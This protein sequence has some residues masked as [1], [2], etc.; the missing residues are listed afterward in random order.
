MEQD[1]LSASTIESH[2]LGLA[3]NIRRLHQIAFQLRD[4]LSGDHWRAVNQLLYHPAFNKKVTIDETLAWLDAV[5]V[6][7]TT[8]S[9]FALDSMNRDTGFRFLSIGRRLERLGFMTRLFNVACNEGRDAGLTWLLELCDSVITYRSRYMSQPHWLPVM[10]L[11]VRDISNPRALMFQ[12]K[13]ILEYMHRLSPNDPGG[14]AE[15][16]KASALVQALD[17]HTDFQP[18]SVKMLEAL[19]ALHNATYTLSDELTTRFFTLP[20]GIQGNWSS[21]WH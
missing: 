10:D 17:I 3:S 16:E 9:G 4:R 11:L 13:G 6:N 15:L 2:P 12:V 7:M 20:G 5:V 21:P 8:L 1:L 19:N 14:Q 18:D